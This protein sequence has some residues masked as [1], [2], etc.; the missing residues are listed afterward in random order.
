MITWGQ[1]CAYDPA[2][3]TRKVRGIILLDAW[4][5]RVNFPELKQRAREFYEQHKPDSLI[6]ES[7][8]TGPPLIQELRKVGL[9]VEEMGAHRGQDKTTK[10]NAVADMFSSGAIWAPLNRRWAHE[11]V[12][13]MA[14]FPYGEFD[15][16]HDAAV[17]GLL[18]LR[19]GG[20]R[21]ATDQGDEEWKPRP[22]REYY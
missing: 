11:V 15:D 16:L 7:K 10:T 5:G 1:F 22:A 14:S 8:A 21:I 6:I 12:E 18:R 17:L 9:L 2:D 19:R 4:A 13:E 3:R 20:F